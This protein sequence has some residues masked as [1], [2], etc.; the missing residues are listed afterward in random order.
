MLPWCYEHSCSWVLKS[1][2]EC[3]QVLTSA[4]R[5]SAPFS[6]VLMSFEECSWPLNSAYVSSWRHDHECWRLL[7]N[8]HEHSWALQALIS[9]LQYSY[10]W[11]WCQCTV[12]TRQHLVSIRQHSL[13]LKSAHST[14]ATYFQLILSVQ[15]AHECS[16]LLL[17]AH[18]CSS[19][20]L[21]NTWNVNC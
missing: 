6:I 10:Y 18:D 14:M 4:H 12:S 3:S 1:A 13:P 11:A 19:T 8:T 21:K 9:T 7:M 16:R 20:W 2:E 5:A 15:N 17:S